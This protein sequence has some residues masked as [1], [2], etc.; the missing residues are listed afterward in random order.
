MGFLSQKIPNLK[1]LIWIRKS[2]NRKKIFEKLRFF[3]IWHIP[4]NSAILSKIPGWRFPVSQL[5]SPE[6]QYPGIG[7][8]SWDE[9]SQQS[10]ISGSTLY[11][12]GPSPAIQHLSA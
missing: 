8:F 9:I 2:K 1:I 7:I 11:K 12:L 3:G 5:K 4:E 10:A 6:F